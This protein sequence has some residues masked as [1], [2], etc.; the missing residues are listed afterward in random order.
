MKKYLAV[1]PDHAKSMDTQQLRSHFLLQ[2]LFTPGQINLN[3]SHYD[4][5]MV[6][7]AMPTTSKLLLETPEGLKANF[8][9][10]RREMGIVNVGDSGYVIVDGAEFQLENKEAL[11]IGRGSKEIVFSNA[12]KGQSLFYINSCSAHATYPTRKVTIS[13]AETSTLGSQENANHRTIRKLIVRSILPTCQL[14]MG[15]TELHAGSVWNTLPPHT[16]DRRMEVYFYFN[17]PKDNAVCHFMGEPTETRHLWIRNHEAIFSPAWSIHSGAGT[18]SYAF[19]WSM[20]GENLDYTD[21][22]GVPVNDL[23]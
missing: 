15:M 20:A 12:G 19:I 6:G 18:S 3:Y 8:F 13:E 10:E 21:M 17:V 14:Q 22:D 9:L 23:R 11:Y 1:H 7:G 5:M 4:R 16:H 2:N